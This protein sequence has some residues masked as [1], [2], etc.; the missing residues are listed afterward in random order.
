[1]STTTATSSSSA[2]PSSLF[3]SSSTSSDKT[4]EAADRF[5]KLLVTQMQ[6][7]DP[8]NPMDNA[9]MTSQMAQISTVTGIEK[10]N[11]TMEGVGSSFSQMQ[12]M[13]GVSLVG[14]QVV[15]EGNQLSMTDG[16]GIGGFEINSAATN[17]TVEIKDA[18]GKVVDT[19]DLGAAKAGQHGFEWTPSTAAN[20][21][22]YTFSVKA[23]VGSTELPATSLVTDH[24]DAVT[25]KD[26]T[27]NLQLRN[28]GEVAYSKV[29][30]LS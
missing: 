7:Q 9:Q 20:S 21:S 24:V 16:S 14:H 27:L 18:G 17:V 28:G 3:N 15:V 5:L 19:I 1:M 2:L 10:L 4:N 23:K 6:N 11:T 22:S 8:L 25:T 30:A 12:L 13:Q 29:K 26:G